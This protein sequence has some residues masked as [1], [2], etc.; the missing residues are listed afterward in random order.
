MVEIPFEGKF[1]IQVFHFFF[2][3]FGTDLSQ[4]YRKLKDLILP[5]LGLEV[6]RIKKYLGQQKPDE[7]YQNNQ[8]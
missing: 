2:L 4:Y 6:L 3:S 5:S 7:I 1:L 8:F